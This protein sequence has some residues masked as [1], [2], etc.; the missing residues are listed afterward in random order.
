MKACFI[1]SICVHGVQGGAVYLADDGFLFRCQKATLEAEY[2]NVRI[3]Y[4]NIKSVSA[5]KRVLFIPTTVMETRDGRKYRFLI[6]NRKRFMRC[7]EQ[8]LA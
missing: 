1:A 6:F 3:L 4:E 8:R 2:K 5:G 7:I